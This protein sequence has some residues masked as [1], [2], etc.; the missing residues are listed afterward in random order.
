MYV[1]AG[2]DVCACVQAGV[3]TTA[4]VRSPP[5]TDLLSSI[6]RIAGGPYHTCATN[7]IGGTFCW[8]SNSKGELG[9]GTTTNSL[10]PPAS[11]VRVYFQ[12]VFAYAE[13]GCT[14]L[15]TC[16]RSTGEGGIRCWGYNG[17]G[18]LGLGDTTTRFSP[19]A[20]AV[21]LGAAS[22]APGYDH[23]C[24]LSTAGTAKCWGDNG[25]GQLGIGT[26]TYL[27]TPPSTDIA[28]NVVSIVASSRHT[29]LLF[30]SSG[31]RCFGFNGWW[32]VH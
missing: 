22:L 31:V 4:D 13:V 11:G 7:S 9:D 30:T 3:G 23:I 27:S 24:T 14:R 2:V 26:L 32:Q 17:A 8:G 6:V 18:Q 1:W 21:L 28:T 5:G 29:C 12:P 20:G 10:V 25:Y 19:P 16:V 15:G